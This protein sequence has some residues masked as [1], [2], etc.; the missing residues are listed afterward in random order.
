MLDTLTDLSSE[1][2]L[3]RLLQT[4]V[5]R[6]VTLLRVTGGELAIFEEGPGELEIVASHNIGSDSIGTRLSMGEG[7]MGRVAET[8]EP[9]IIPDYRTFDGRSDKYADTTARG[10][11]VVPLMIGNRLVGTLAS[12]HLEEG[13]EFGPEDLRLLNLF[14]PQAAIAI[15]NAR[16]YTEAKRQ[17]QYFQTVVENSPVAIVTLDLDGRIASLNPAF[18]TLFG[19]PPAEALG[20]DL[21]ELITTGET[22]LEAKRR[23]Q[24]VF[25]GDITRGIGRRKRRDGSFIDVEF[26]GVLVDVD[27]RS[28]GI[29]A[30]YHDITELLE[31]R[32]DAEAASRAKSQFLA[33]MSHELR[34][35]LNAIIGYSEMLQEDAEE[36]GQEEFVPDLRK[37]HSAGRHLLALINDILDL[38]KIEAGRMELYL[39]SFD[40]GEVIEQV[41]TTIQPLIAKNGNRL[42]V[43][44]AETIGLLRSDATRLRQVLLNLLSNASKFTENGS[45]T[46]EAER[47]TPTDSEGDWVSIAV[48]DTGIGMS[49]EQLARLF[50]AFSQAEASTAKRYGGT[51]LG[52][53]ISRSFCRLMGGDI[54]VDSEPGAGS[55]FTVRI[56]VEAPESPPDT[57]SGSAATPEAGAGSSGI[58]PERAVG[59]ILTIDDDPAARSLLRRILERES[60]RVVEATDGPDGLQKARES[61]PDCITLDVMMPGMDGWEV[62]A[63]LKRDPR[64]AGIPVVMVSILDERHLGFSLGA[65]DYLTKPID[66]DRLREVLTRFTDGSD[67]ATVLI[68]EDDPG[69][70]E[71]LRRT[72]D[73]EGWATH[74]AEHGRAA[75]AELESIRP[76]LI[77]LDLMMPEMDGF[78]FLES[79]RSRPDRADIPVVVLTAMDL[80]AEDRARLNGGVE[81]VVSKGGGPPA[82]LLAELRRLVGPDVPTEGGR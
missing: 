29:V 81:R 33:S 25:A 49:D 7:A 14:A 3:S 21:D 59:T 4:V 20:R 71:S 66:R 47:L 53:A 42:E 82:E 77:L 11:V 43:R 15:E 78:E 55:T 23:T 26:A 62:L 18:E 56:P 63:E 54:F 13:R 79:L 64:L 22:K 37:I 31:A 73:R 28:A 57:V 65:S 41:V 2:E 58:S 19:Y 16:L 51:G 61:L 50:E 68:V 35:P 70:R 48:R 6:A 40:A 39:E 12:V 30:L 72:F 24:Q 74:T 67:R 60:F 75:L 46:L 5:E 1:L 69:T 76:T 45:I 52:L 10:V 32:Q 8:R 80:S 38:S 44:G 9:L 27:G 34:T 17:R 36:E